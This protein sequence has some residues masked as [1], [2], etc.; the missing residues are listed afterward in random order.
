MYSDGLQKVW[1]EGSE[2]CFTDKN[3]RLHRWL[4]KDVGES[5]EI[6]GTIFLRTDGLEYTDASK[7]SRRVFEGNLAS[8]R[9]QERNHTD[10][11]GDSNKPHTDRHSDSGSFTESNAILLSVLENFADSKSNAFN[12][13]PIH[14]D[15]HVDQ[16]HSDHGDV[17]VDR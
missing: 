11:H 9:S 15:A 12:V 1:I 8:L 16:P 6:P 7:R 13:N 17:H 3:S 2:I 5:S 14:T 4:G 10:L